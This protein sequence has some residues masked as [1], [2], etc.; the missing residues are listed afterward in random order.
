[1]KIAVCLSG[2]LRNFDCNFF[3]NTHGN[4]D[5]F[6]HTWEYCDTNILKLN[7]IKD[8]KVEPD[9]NA[10]KYTTVD[11]H[12]WPHIGN[13][14][15]ENVFK[16]YYGMKRCIE[17]VEDYERK[18]NFKYDLIIRSRYDIRSNTKNC[19]V[20][21]QPDGSFDLQTLVCNQN[22]II[23]P[24]KGFW[25]GKTIDTNYYTYDISDLR[26]R[27]LRV[28]DSYFIGNDACRTLSKTYDYFDT[29]KNKYKTKL[30][31]ENLISSMCIIHNM[32]IILKNFE[33]NLCRNGRPS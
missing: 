13:S 33:C 18:N 12:S 11:V 6:C 24:L 23:F 21:D 25:V 15:R 22:D 10:F 30:H 27:S 4:L 17:M 28:N 19:G 1:M 5:I 9:S 14:P 3:S 16:M 2:L 20:S 7:N 29:L 32:N 8:I 31:T 26:N